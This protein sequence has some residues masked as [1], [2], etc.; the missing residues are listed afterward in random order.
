MLKRRQISWVK[1]GSSNLIFFNGIAI[2]YN[3]KLCLMGV[4]LDMT[5]RKKM[6]A[7]LRES[8]N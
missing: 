7:G 6:E 5:E 3:D 8:G 2:N 4:G 1:D